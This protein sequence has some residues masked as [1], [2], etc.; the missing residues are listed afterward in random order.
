M[1]QGRKWLVCRKGVFKRSLIVSLHFNYQQ[2]V[3]SR[4][5]SFST[6]LHTITLVTEYSCFD[7]CHQ[8]PESTQH[9]VWLVDK[10]V[11]WWTGAGV[12]HTHTHDSIHFYR[13]SCASWPCTGLQPTVNVFVC[14]SLAC[15][16]FE[17]YWL[18]TWAEQT[19]AAIQRPTQPVNIVHVLFALFN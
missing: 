7:A 15:L 3:F 16:S 17:Y 12:W 9:N 14:R 8:P 5:H 6:L 10:P 4:I 13:I 2:S 19:I 18:F 1:G 11:K